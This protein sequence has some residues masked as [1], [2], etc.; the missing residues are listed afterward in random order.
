MNILFHCTFSDQKEWLKSLKKKFRGH[1]FFTI[2]DKFNYSN[3]SVAIIW[4]L[5]DNIYKKLVI[6][7]L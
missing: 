2:K 5:P 6:I 3:I 7:I 1:K 4:N